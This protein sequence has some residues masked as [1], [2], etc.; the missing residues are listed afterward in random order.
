MADPFPEKTVQLIEKLIA[1]FRA[2]HP[3]EKTAY[4][5]GMIVANSFFASSYGFASS[6]SSGY[7]A[8]YFHERQELNLPTFNC[9]TIIP[10]IYLYSVNFGLKAEIVQFYDFKD[11]YKPEDK[12]DPRSPQHFSV[13]LDV[14][15]EHKYLLD[16]FY[17]IYGPILKRGDDYLLLGK[18]KSKRTRR[19][20]SKMIP[21]SPEEFVALMEHI[22]TPTGSLDM[23]IA[24]QKVFEHRKIAKCSTTLMVYYDD[25]TNTLFTRL[26]IPQ[27]AITDKAIYC[28]MP[29]DDD[30]KAATPILEL[31]LAKKASWTDLVE[32]KK[33]ATIRFNDLYKIKKTLADVPVS[34]DGKKRRLQPYDRLGATLLQ[35]EEKRQTL[36]EVADKLLAGLATWEKRKLEPLVLMRTLYE[37][38]APE[39]EYLYSTTEQDAKRL[40]F[41]ERDF[42]MVKEK[43]LLE[44]TLFFHNW[45]LRCLSRN[46]AE[47][48]KRQK[49]RLVREK[50]KLVKDIDDFNFFRIGHKKMYSRT[51]DKVLF[52]QEVGNADL[53]EKIA[54][55]GLDPR[56]GYLAMVWD[57]IP[58]ALEGKKDLT[59]ALFRDSIAEKVKA[60][61]NGNYTSLTIADKIAQTVPATMEDQLPEN[62]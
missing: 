44:E 18:G 26:Y 6:L 58:F 33:I 8:P 61:R 57:F 3:E 52:A 10:D 38:T 35:S 60:R 13:I 46:D 34:F 41:V 42:V 53:K 25:R 56:F 37:F 23:L 21:Y 62:I 31:L 50:I 22:R 24:G 27:V 47:K 4:Q 32:K 7:Y 1:D 5:R 14:G 28:R 29:L 54:E 30:G 17:Q 19:V 43:E 59:L 12:K 40:D 49:K 15:R 48:V 2:L 16:P 11:I 55:Q 20:F 45:K 9:T 39:K 36:L 51:M